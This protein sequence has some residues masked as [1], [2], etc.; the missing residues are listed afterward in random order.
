MSRRSERLASLIRTV[1]AAEID[2]LH[3][4][5]IAP[6]T[7]LTSVELSPDFSVANVYVSVM[8]DAVRG[9]L[10]LRALRH[11]AGHLQSALAGQVRMRQCPRLR[12]TLDESLKRGFEVLE[13][14]DREM[15]AL[16]EKSAC[17]AQ[18]DRPDADDQETH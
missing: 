12:F 6:V 7:S 9:R 14:I 13:L 1:L 17:L 8:G 10:C 4:P 2:T 16:D 3:D 18:S 11:A 5:R 15:A